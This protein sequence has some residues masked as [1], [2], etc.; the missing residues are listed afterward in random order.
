MIISIIFEKNANQLKN[1]V[2]CVL[3]KSLE[4]VIILTVNFP[5]D[6]QIANISFWNSILFQ[7]CNHR[8]TGAFLTLNCFHFFQFFW[9]IFSCKFSYMFCSSISCL[10]RRLTFIVLWIFVWHFIRMEWIRQRLKITIG[11]V[12]LPDRCKSVQTVHYLAYVYVLA[13]HACDFIVTVIDVSWT[14]IPSSYNNVGG[15]TC[16]FDT[17]KI[18]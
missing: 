2:I 17:L 3:N 6:C 9:F 10:I 18:S 1:C 4:H 16:F 8:L 15:W 14:K 7:F 13:E 5:I 11:P 12:V